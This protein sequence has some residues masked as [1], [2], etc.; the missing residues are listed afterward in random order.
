M[1]KECLNMW[2]LLEF[3]L[4]VPRLR[5]L[6]SNLVTAVWLLGFNL[7][8]TCA[9]QMHAPA[10]WNPDV[11]L[12]KLSLSLGLWPKH[13]PQS[14]CQ[15]VFFGVKPHRKYQSHIVK[16]EKRSFGK[17]SNSLSPRVGSSYMY[18]T[19]TYILGFFLHI[20]NIYICVIVYTYSIHAVH[21]EYMHTYAYLYIYIYIFVENIYVPFASVQ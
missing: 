8:V 15:N 11:G 13:G 21:I 1:P 7:W 10:T 9:S 5:I 6:S 17:V 12:K 19:Y 14:I 3:K 16:S 2:G 4:L 20:Y 18:N